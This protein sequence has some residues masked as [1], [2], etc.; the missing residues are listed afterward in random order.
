MDRA[1]NPR[2]KA[3]KY[4]A[5]ESFGVKI[6]VFSAREEILDEIEGRIDKFLPTGL[7]E[8]IPYRKA[9]HSF[10]IR[11]NRTSK[12]VLFKGRKK[13]TYGNN[14]EIFFKYLDSQIR[15]TIAEFAESRVFIHAGVVEWKG[16]A[17]VLPARSFQG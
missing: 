15:L 5:I 11:E 4:I 12:F 7:F 13:I 14:K 2:I 1:G 8:K 10:S 6:R 3:K 17:I 16:E 9:V